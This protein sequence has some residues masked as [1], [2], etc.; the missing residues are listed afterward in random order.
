MSNFVTFGILQKGTSRT[1]RHKVGKQK[2]CKM[3]NIAITIIK[4]EGVNGR[5]NQKFYQPGESVVIYIN[6][7]KIDV[8]EAIASVRDSKGVFSSGRV[9]DAYNEIRKEIQTA[10]FDAMMAKMDMVEAQQNF[11]NSL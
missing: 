4:A 1:P 5:W 3:K 8:T 6:N 10:K 7:E 11:I 2:L 9:I